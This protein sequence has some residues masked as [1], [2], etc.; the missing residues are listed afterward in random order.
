MATREYKTNGRTFEIVMSG[1][2]NLFRDETAWCVEHVC[3]GSRHA[4]AGFDNIVTS[5]EDATYDAAC[6]RI[7][8]MSTPL[9]LA[10]KR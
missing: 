6:R 9:K 8:Q 5:S 1:T 7:D 4:I 3:E 10:A 2:P